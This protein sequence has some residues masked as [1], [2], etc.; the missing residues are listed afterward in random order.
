MHVCS[1]RIFARSFQ[2]RKDLAQNVFFELLPEYN[3]LPTRLGN[4]WAMMYLVDTCTLAMIRPQISNLIPP[5][6]IYGN[7]RYSFC[8]F[9]A[10][11]FLHGL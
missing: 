7:I 3:F 1:D 5:I 10:Q 4:R 9:Q 2:K 6:R 11:S 8:F